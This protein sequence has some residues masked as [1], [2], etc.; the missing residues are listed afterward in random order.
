MYG[1]LKLWPGF[2]EKLR[3]LFLTYGKY[4]IHG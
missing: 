1:L 4:M 3:E 2:F